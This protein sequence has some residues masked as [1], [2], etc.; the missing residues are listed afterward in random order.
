MS[1]RVVRIGAVDEHVADHED[2]R[3]GAVAHPAAADGRT[4]GG[5]EGSSPSPIARLSAEISSAVGGAITTVSSRASSAV[6]NPDIACFAS[7]ANSAAD[8]DQ[9]LY[10]I[11]QLPSISWPSGRCRAQVPSAGG[12]VRWAKSSRHVPGMI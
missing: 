12:P 6:A 11:V 4:S 9:Q 5:V 3:F 2:P 7:M 8:G 10:D 1:E